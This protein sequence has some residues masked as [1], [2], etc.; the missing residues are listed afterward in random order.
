MHSSAYNPQ[1][2]GTIER[3]HKTMNQGLSHY[4][5]STGTDWDNLIPFYMMAY[6]G[7]PHGTHGFS[8][9]YLLHGREMIL[10]TSQGL[11]AKLTAEVRETENV[12]RLE[13]LKSTLQSAYKTVRKNNCKSHDTNKRYYDQRAKERQ[14]GPGEIVYL[15][16][17]ARKPGQSSKCFFAWQGP[18]K[19]TARLSKLNYHVVNQ[20]GKEFVVHLNRMKKAFKQGIWKEQ[21]WERYDRKQRGRQPEQ[22]EEQVVIAHRP[23]TIPVPK[24]ENRQQVPG[25]PNRSPPRDVN[26]PSTAPQFSEPREMRRDPTF[27]PEDTPVKRRE[28]GTTRSRPPITRLQSRLQALEETAEPVGE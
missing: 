13:K 2:N 14:F 12:H 10:P 17:P 27:V 20:Q 19:V 18:Y 11:K 15:F 5:N 26:T 16:N 8:P 3:L 28:L 9:F 24:G 7:T 6:R 23:V 22:E 21:K 1:G 4:V 25:T